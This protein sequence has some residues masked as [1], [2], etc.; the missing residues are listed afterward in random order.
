[1]QEV[2]DWHP[3]LLPPILFLNTALLM[4]SSLTMEIARQQMFNEMNSLEEWLGLGYPALKRALPWITATLVLGVL[5]LAGQSLA[6]RQ[7]SLQGFSFTKNATPVSYFFYIITGMHAAHLVLG[8]CLLGFCVLG[9]RGLK[10]VDLRQI[11]VDACAW[12]WHTM[13]VAW[14]VLFAVLWL[15]Q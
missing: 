10:S 9:L 4:L 2:G 8:V 3:I 15:G 14:L 6:W 13:G 11:T 12:F 5:F 7:L 1:M